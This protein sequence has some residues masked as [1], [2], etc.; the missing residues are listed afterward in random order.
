[1]SQVSVLVAAHDAATT[2]GA[3]LKSVAQQELRAWECVVVDDGSTD[4]T[5]EVVRSMAASD[6]RFRLIQQPHQGVVAARNAGIQ[7]CSSP[8]VAILD[9]D[10]CMHPRRLRLQMEAFE[11]RPQL[12][13][14]GTHVRYTPRESMAA[15]RRAYEEWLNSHTSPADLWRDRFVEM[16]L[17][18]PTMTV[19]ASLLRATPYRDMGWPEDWDLL[20]R[21]FQ[22][23]GPDAIDVV[24][25]VLHDWALHEDSLSSQSQAYS[26]E[27][28]TRCRAAFLA[29][30]F[31][32]EEESYALMGY[33][34]TGKALRKAL[35]VYGKTCSRIY[36]LHPGRIGQEMD[37]A[38]VVSHDRLLDQP[39]P[40]KTKLLVSVSGLEARTALRKLLAQ[41]G[42]RDTEDFICC[43]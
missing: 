41:V 40:S 23:V 32:G 36:E 14:L 38:E 2:L 35:S 6:A 15:G 8:F 21:I 31:L 22:L 20:Q 27:A 37:G 30:D 9:A 17:G 13:A 29:S 34:D 19:R 1:M 10:D 7:A 3:T 24:P 5:A 43:A 25:E 26:V 39:H 4:G 11:A 18:H 28:F 12:H 33:G 16:P 42:L